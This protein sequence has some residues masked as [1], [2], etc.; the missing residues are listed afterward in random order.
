MTLPTWLRDTAVDTI[1]VTLLAGAVLAGW[2]VQGWRKDAVIADLHLAAAQA[3]EAAALTLVRATDEARQREQGAAKAQQDRANKLIKERDD[4]KAD[5]DHFIAGVRSGA[6]RLSIPV[7]SRSA[8]A[9]RAD[10]G[11]VAGNRVETRAELDPEAAQFLDA[12]A[13]EGDD[14]IRQ[15]NACIDTYNDVRKKF[16]VQA[17]QPQK[18]SD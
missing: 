14:A 2:T 13:S 3:D 4:A 12:I 15:L 17:G 16:N 18:T 1:L 6:I 11:T 8:D 7:V 10:A 9:S 5:R